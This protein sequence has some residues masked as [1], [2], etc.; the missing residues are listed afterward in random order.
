VVEARSARQPGRDHEDAVSAVLSQA[1]HAVIACVS[2][3]R[4][5][6]RHMEVARFGATPAGGVDRPALSPAEVQAR[7]YLLDVA[8]ARGL[9]PFTDPAGNFFLRLEGADET[10][11][12][13][14]TGSHLDSQPTGGK[15]DGIYGVLAGLEVLE[16]FRD[17]GMRPRRAIET[18]AWMNEEGGRFAPGMMGSEAFAGTRALESILAAR[19]GA[20]CTVKDALAAVNDAVPLPSRPLGF[21]IAGY[22]EAHIEQG[23][24]LEATGCVIGAVTGIQGKQTYRVTVTGEEAHAGTKPMQERRDALMAAL[25]MVKAMHDLCRARDART[26]FTVGRFQVEPNAPSVVP[27]RVTFSI[28][29]RHFETAIMRDLGASFARIC[30]DHA[31]PCE[32]RIETLVDAPS[33]VFPEELRLRTLALAEALGHPAMELPSAAGHDARHLND[34]APSAMVFV[35]CRNG[36]SHHES[37][38][39]EPQHLFAGAQVLAGLVCD[40]VQGMTNES[41]R[42]F[43]GAR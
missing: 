26:L 35:P 22:I 37:E 6:R 34:V 14:L 38:W 11:P 18:V 28:D 32:V 20:D 7:R 16:A 41:G 30:G 40:A 21:P 10:L 31:G 29:L 17:A 2:A 5:W 25:A 33:L 27:A 24:V 42:C 23:P 1:A 15:F 39:A 19:D 43:P 4:L 3:E 13:V 12:P 36:V 9:K 8:A